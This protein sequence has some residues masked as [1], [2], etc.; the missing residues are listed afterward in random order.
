MGWS[1]LLK[2]PGFLST[3]TMATLTEVFHVFFPVKSRLFYSVF[4]NYV[5]LLN[6]VINTKQLDF[7][8]RRFFEF[9]KCSM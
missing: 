3:G 5:A 7:L 9:Q 8:L 1:R 2:V 6:T 4:L